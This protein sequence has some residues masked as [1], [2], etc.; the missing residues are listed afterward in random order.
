MAGPL[1]GTVGRKKACIGNHPNMVGSRVWVK[2]LCVKERELG[3][4][5]KLGS[6]VCLPHLRYLQTAPI[7]LFA[8]FHGRLACVKH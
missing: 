5:E 1:P 6:S 8:Y 7:R 3:A 2:L 4:P